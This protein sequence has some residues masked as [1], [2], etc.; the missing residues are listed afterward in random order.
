VCASVLA[1]V[2]AMNSGISSS[3]W[4]GFG[5]YMVAMLAFLWASRREA[6]PHP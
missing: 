3:F 5:A 6:V 2:I 4:T 1:V